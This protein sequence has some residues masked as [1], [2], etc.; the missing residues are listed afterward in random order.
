[1][2]MGSPP[3]ARSSLRLG[4]PT[5]RGLGRLTVIGSV[6]SDTDALHC[7]GALVGCQVHSGNGQGALM[8]SGMSITSTTTGG[9]HRP[10]Q[11]STTGRQSQPLLVL[12]RPY[13]QN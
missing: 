9:D 2:R 10:Q 6:V 3:G 13:Q 1:M 11:S 5:A 7:H 12:D 4:T 8:K